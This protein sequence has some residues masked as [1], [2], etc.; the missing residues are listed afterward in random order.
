MAIT[1]QLTLLREVQRNPRHSY[2]QQKTRPDGHA[3][4]RDH[5]KR[6]IPRIRKMNEPHQGRHLGHLKQKHS[7]PRYQ[8][9][10]RPIPARKQGRNTNPT[11][12]GNKITLTIPPI[13]Q[14]QSE[15][16]ANP[17]TTPGH[18]LKPTGRHQR[19][20]PETEHRPRTP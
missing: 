18:Q 11:Q 12:R 10:Q 7:L 4:L 5:E 13:R 19:R 1:P 8:R 14:R 6:V 3:L 2:G 16:R 20:S 9:Q 17:G 15:H